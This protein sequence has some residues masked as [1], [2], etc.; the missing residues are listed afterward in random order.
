MKKASMFLIL[1]LTL[2]A[3]SSYAFAW[4]PRVEGKPNM[5]QP[6]EIKG[7]FIWHNEHGIHIWTSTRNREHV[8]S[9][10]IRTDG[11]F[12]D[13]RGQRLETND[14]Y[15]VENDRH[16]IVFRDTTGAHG[17]DGLNFQIEY[18]DHMNFDLFMDGE[19]IDPQNIYVGENG[20]HPANSD[21]S[22]RVR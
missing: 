18:S 21:F 12:I 3:C 20:W 10:V 4:S 16:K 1:V 9:G 5:F 17:S 11:K 8:F 6:G 14:F 19:R 7:Y 15:K 2:L 22:L 13:V